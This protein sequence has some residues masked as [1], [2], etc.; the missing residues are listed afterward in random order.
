[1]T[2]LRL[3]KI[4]IDTYKESVAYLYR[5]CPLYHTEGF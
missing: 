2:T 1:M 4:A 5:D 3:R